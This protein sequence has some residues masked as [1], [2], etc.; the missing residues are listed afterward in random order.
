VNV[1]APALVDRLGTGIHTVL[2]TGTVVADGM[3]RPV[4][5]YGQTTVSIE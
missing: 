2:V 1:P 3:G 5:M 4:T